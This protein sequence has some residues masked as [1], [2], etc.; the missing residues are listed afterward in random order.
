MPEFSKESKLPGEYIAGFVDGEGCFD[1]QF[2]RDVRHERVN[3][4]AYYSWKAQFVIVLRY[5]EKE[6]LK[7]IKDTIGC[8][9]IY[10]SNGNQ[11][12]YSVQDVDNLRNRI[13]PFFKKFLLF[14][15]KK[16]DFN[17]WAESI[18]I[19]Y[20]NKRKNININKGVRG[21]T[22]INWNKK[23]FLRLIDIQKSMQ[24]FKA[25]RSRAL[26]WFPIAESIAETL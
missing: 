8:G 20:R 4:P 18:E 24:N 5:D 7:K 23:D 19:I 14:G 13:V 1:L 10:S 15:K 17:L 25:K 11:V 16:Q 26:K 12:R 21:F 9:S 22:R 3:S 6:L 2:R